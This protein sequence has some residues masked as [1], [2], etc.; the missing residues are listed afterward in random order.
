[1]RQI[2]RDLA[3]AGADEKDRV[4]VSESSRKRGA[5]SVDHG[6]PRGGERRGIAR[7]DVGELQLGD[8]LLVGW[9]VEQPRDQAIETGARRLLGRQR[10]H[11][12]Q[13]LRAAHRFV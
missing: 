6:A 11:E 8:E 5:R 12:A 1:V 10:R 7:V 9:R 2:G 4:L 3:F 13:R